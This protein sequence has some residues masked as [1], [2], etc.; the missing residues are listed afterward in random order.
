MNRNVYT[1]DLY[2]DKKTKNIDTVND[3]NIVLLILSEEK[4]RKKRNK[5]KTE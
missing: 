4:G 2:L 1:Q 5:T 3:R